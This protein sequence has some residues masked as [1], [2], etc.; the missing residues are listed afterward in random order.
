MDLDRWQRI[1]R[2]FHSVCEL[3]AS[4]RAAFLE[5]ACCG[6]ELLRREVMSLLKQSEGADSFLEAP[7]MEMAAKGSSA[8]LWRRNAARPGSFG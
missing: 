4:Q 3:E 6:D 2:L 5:Q 7:A 8:V 1:E